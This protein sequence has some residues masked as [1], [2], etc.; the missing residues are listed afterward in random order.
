MQLPVGNDVAADIP[1]A[2]R[3]ADRVE[4]GCCVQYKGG[5]M[6]YGKMFIT[7]VE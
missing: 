7:D 1:I 3:N 5:V 2:Q 6:W 4:C